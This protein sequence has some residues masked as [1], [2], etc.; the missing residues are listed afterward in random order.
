ML[1]ES[2]TNPALIR[3]LAVR[4]TRVAPIEALGRAMVL[5]LSERSGVPLVRLEHDQ[6]MTEHDWGR[7][8]QVAAELS[9]GPLQG[10]GQ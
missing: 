7:V 2:D 6:C 10:G 9:K 1:D 5:L 8:I 3:E 4:L